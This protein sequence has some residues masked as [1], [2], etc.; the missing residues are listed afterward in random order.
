MPDDNTGAQ[1]RAT[2]MLD[3][4]GG[5]WADKAIVYMLRYGLRFHADIEWA[6]V[7]SPPLASAADHRETLDATL[8]KQE[9]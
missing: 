3:A 1:E 7:L 9:A 4:V 6:L 8:K 2:A 5:E